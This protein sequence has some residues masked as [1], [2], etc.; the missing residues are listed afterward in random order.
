MNTFKPLLLFSAMMV[1]F[2]LTGCEQQAAAPE[3]TSVSPAKERSRALTSL[4]EAEHTE[5]RALAEQPTSIT[6]DTEAV[7]AKASALLEQA[8]IQLERNDLEGAERTIDR[9][10]GVKPSVSFATR[11]RIDVARRLLEVKRS[12]ATKKMPG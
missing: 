7:E 11:E 4:P 9:L 2:T 6:G 10:E 12:T 8:V 3:S 1:T 5:R